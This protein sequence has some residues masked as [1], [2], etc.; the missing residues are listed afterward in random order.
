MKKAV[1]HDLAKNIPWIAFPWPGE[2]ITVSFKN[3]L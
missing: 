3:R 2:I 1:A